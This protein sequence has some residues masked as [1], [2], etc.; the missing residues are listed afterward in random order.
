MRGL[1]DYL[2]LYLK[3]LSMGAADV[4]PGVSGG[5]A[6]FITGVYEELI[7]SLRAID[8]N[9]VKLLGSFQFSAFWKKING[10]FLL[11]VLTG[12]ITSMLTVS[13]VMFTLLERN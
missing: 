5:T 13:R 8:T 4:I 9:A 11:L 3:G 1:K 2:L 7:Y 12:I 10:T 6:A